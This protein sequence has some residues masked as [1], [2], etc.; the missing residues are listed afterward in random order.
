MNRG[1]LVVFLMFR[2][3]LHKVWRLVPRSVR[4]RVVR[5]VLPDLARKDRLGSPRGPIIVVGAFRSDTSFGWLSRTLSDHLSRAGAPV[6]EFDLS[7]GFKAV[8]RPARTA[9]QATAD[10][11]AGEATVILVGTPDQFAYINTFLPDGALNRKYV[12]GYCAW[13]LERLPD[14]WLAPAHALDRVWGISQFVTDAFAASLPSLPGAVVPCLA[15]PQTS[16]AA[17]RDRFGFDR[18]T[19]VILVVFSLRSGL[20]R[21]N[22]FAAIAAFRKA[23]PGDE[24]VCLVLKVADIAI[25]PAAFA[26]LQ[27]AVAGDPRIRFLTEQLPEADMWSLLASADIVLSLHRA[28]GFGLVPAQAMLLGKP[29]VMTGWSSVLEFADAESA[30]L[31]N[32]TLVPVA[33]PAG[34]FTAPLRWAEPDVDAAARALRELYEDPTARTT[35]GDRAARR[36]EAYLAESDRQVAAAVAPLVASG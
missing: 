2:L 24:R 22:P 20:E 30:R 11:F 33:D 8:D 14:D 27:A 16:V 23:F 12:I 5:S 6:A 18:D 28:E 35:L 13:E 32:C 25:E 26:T 34:R 21:K 31:I 36:I 4:R 9:R 10:L 7:A 3:G 15:P 1:D 29:V 17:N 19:C